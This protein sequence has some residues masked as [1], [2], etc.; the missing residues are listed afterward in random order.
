MEG[1]SELTFD[2]LVDRII[3]VDDSLRQQAAHAVNCLLTSRNWLIG[4]YI[5]E[6][7]Q[8]GA[9]RAQYGEQLLKK[10]AK[11]IDRK[12]MEWRR[13]YEYRTFYNV[14]PQLK[15][16]I[17]SYLR[18]QRQNI[19]N[20]RNLQS[21]TAISYMLENDDYIIL[22]PLVAISRESW[23]VAP[24]RLFHCISYSS[25][26]ILSEI[27]DSLKRSF[28]EHEL[29]QYCW[30]KRQLDHQ[31]SSLYYERSALSRNKEALK[32][33][34]QKGTEI[35][36]PKYILRDP[37][38]LDFLDIPNDEVYTETKLE[39]AILNNLQKFLLELGQ[40]FCFEARQKRILIDHDYF[41]ADLIFYNRILHCHVIIDLKI[42]RYRHEYAS[43][44]NMYKNFYRHEMMQPGDN[45]PIGLLLCTDYSDTLVKYS[46]EGLDDIYV[47]K[48]MFQLPKEEEIRQFLIDNMPVIEDDK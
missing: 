20:D 40:G 3:V 13:L 37:M 2:K 25:L 26:Q 39:N 21:L 16:E 5:V 44:L 34:I 43:Q 6:F 24:S 23:M 8:N 41:K 7:E 48:Y 35:M 17:L 19:P 38:T 15:E 14:Y 12:G 4:C 11:R 32:N 46:T 18:G 31:I 47:G 30:S 29:I 36:D 27:R 45:P 28:Y 1:Q 9:D 42:D 33:Y 22:R 10:L